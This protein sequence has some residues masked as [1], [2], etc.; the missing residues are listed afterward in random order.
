[1]LKAAPAGAHQPYSERLQESWRPLSGGGRGDPAAAEGSA[2]DAPAAL[3]VIGA[4]R[5]LC[6]GF[7]Q[8]VVEAAQRFVE[9]TDGGPRPS[10]SGAKSR[11]DRARR[12]G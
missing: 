8:A 11:N 12:L 10:S 9:S 6:G 7:N 1:M 5:G 2:P 4:D 3:L